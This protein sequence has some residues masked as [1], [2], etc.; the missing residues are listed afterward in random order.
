M[1]ELGE[2]SA[3]G[4]A[5]KPLAK[6]EVK[7]SVRDVCTGARIEGANVLVDGVEK[8]TDSSGEAVFSD[9][10]IGPGDVKVNKHFED[11]DYSIFIVHYPKILRSFE[12]KSVEED[13]V[14]VKSG[15][16][17]K[18]RIEIE[19]YKLVGKV[20]FHRRHIDLGG[21][22]KYGHWW[23]VID[24]STSFGWWPKYPLGSNENRFSEPPEAP[25]AL[26]ENDGNMKRI[27]ER[28]L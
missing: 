12:A 20:E 7:V 27:Q 14:N 23:T 26:S 22:D 24:E 9:L 19:V 1:A 2:K 21:G 18:I 4:K 6:G 16:E 5:V 8:Q 25:A 3:A 15:A 11:A 17:S 28:G 13:L 10:P